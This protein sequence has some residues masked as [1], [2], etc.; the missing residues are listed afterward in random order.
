[1][2]PVELSA[3]ELNPM[4]VATE[5]GS[6]ANFYEYSDA[7]DLDAVHPVITGTMVCYHGCW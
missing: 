4:D 1:M 5:T 6:L 7:G 2:L 3:D